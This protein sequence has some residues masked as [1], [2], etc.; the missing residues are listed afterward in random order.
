MSVAGAVR[1]TS[2]TT[3]CP[4]ATE[5]PITRSTCR[6][7]ARY[8]TRR[9]TPS[10]ARCLGAIVVKARKKQLVER[11][12]LTCGKSLAGTHRKTFCSYECRHRYQYPDHAAKVCEQCGNRFEPDRNVG[13]R[14]RFCSEEC[15]RA[16][17]KENPDQKQVLTTHRFVCENCGRVYE[18]PH[19]SRDKCCSRECGWELN[20]K[21]A[22][23]TK[24]CLSCGHVFEGKR[25]GSD[26]CSNECRDLGKKRVCTVCGAVFFGTESALYCSRECSLEGGRLKYEKWATEKVGDRA[27][28]CKECGREF[29]APYGDKRHAFCSTKCSRRNYRNS[30]KGKAAHAAQRHVRRAREYD[31]GQTDSINPTEVYERDGWRCGICGCKVKRSLKYPHP[32]S[33]SLDHIVPLSKGGTH[34]LQNVQCA[35]LVCNTKKS[36]VGGGQLRLGLDVTV[37][38]A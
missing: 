33:A 32:M 13:K 11:C 16:W 24:T 3:S 6:R 28:I 35:H 20:S 30:S 25:S 2:C 12:C 36:N 31:N 23:V 37:V 21:R 10:W 19:K 29:I 5:D 9:C 38:I 27:Y 22:V 8:V 26:F 18:T 15:Q 14:Q 1:L 4:S 17:W 34:T 7:C